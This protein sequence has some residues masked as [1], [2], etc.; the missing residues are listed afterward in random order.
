[1]LE[2]KPTG[3]CGPMTTGSGQNDLD[4]ENCVVNILHNEYRQSYRYY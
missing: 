1:M 2:V 4:I 3:Q